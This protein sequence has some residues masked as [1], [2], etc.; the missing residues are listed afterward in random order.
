MTIGN[1]FTAS[2][3]LNSSGWTGST[4]VERVQASAMSLPSGAI[5]QVRLTLKAGSS[6]AFTLTKGYV[7]HRAGSGDAY[8]SAA[9][10]VQ[11]K[12]AG[13]NS[14]VISAGTEEVSDWADFS[15]DKTS[16]FLFS[17]Y[18]NG[19]SGDMV[20]YDTGITGVTDY[21]YSSGDQAATVNRTTG[22]SE[23]DGVLV[24]ITKI[25]YKT[26]EGNMGFL[27]FF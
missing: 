11:L 22:Y 26:T 23:N 1:L 2:L 7:S 18:S 21:E 9:T 20:S 12:F 25:E 19:A 16:D 24:L 4:G 8:D 3:T 5:T 13:S 10:P 15:Y 14:K 27:A 6:D 17:F